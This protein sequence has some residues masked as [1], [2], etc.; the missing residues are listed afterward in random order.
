MTKKKQDF[1]QSI[2]QLESIVSALEKGDV[3]LEQAIELYQ[4]GMKL[5]QSCHS[6]L[7]H[8]EKQLV[9]IMDA[10]GKEKVLDSEDQEEG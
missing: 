5:S 4:E 2:A 1:A 7:E 3:P 10:Q 8:A 9:T 6:Q